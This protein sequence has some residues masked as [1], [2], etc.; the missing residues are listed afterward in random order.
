MG[1]VRDTMIVA[2]GWQGVKMCALHD[3]AVQLFGEDRVSRLLGSAVNSHYYFFIGGS[4]SKLG[5]SQ[6]V[7]H[8]SHVGE[9]MQRAEAME[10]WCHVIIIESGEAIGDFE[11]KRFQHS[12]S[13]GWGAVW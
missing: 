11:V 13:M 12:E 7:S 1:Y 9:F 6:A 10:H 8:T 3:N 5:W 2:T 4:G